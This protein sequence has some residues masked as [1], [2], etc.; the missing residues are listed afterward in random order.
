[1]AL[2]DRIDHILNLLDAASQRQDTLRDVATRLRS[3]V[4]WR[5][6]DG[7]MEIGLSPDQKQQ[8]ADVVEAYTR[9]LENITAA[10]RLAMQEK[11]PE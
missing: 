1:M 4:V 10:I 9:D 11:A 6:K 3:G 5:A 8:L 7:R 2:D